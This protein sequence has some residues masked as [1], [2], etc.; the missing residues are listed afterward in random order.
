MF[1]IA[2]LD[3]VKTEYKQ[4]ILVNRTTGIEINLTPAGAKKWLN[5]LVPFFEQR[6]ELSYVSKQSETDVLEE[7]FGL[8]EENT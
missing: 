7:M 3:A 4:P 8:C 6:P 2:K 5:T 1:P